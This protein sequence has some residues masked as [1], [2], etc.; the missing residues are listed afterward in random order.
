MDNEKPLELHNKYAYNK[1]DVPVYIDN[2]D[3][4]RKGYYCMGCRKEMQAVKS[5]TED[6]A[7]YFRHDA[8]AIKHEEKCAFSDEAYRHKLAI[9][10]L[11]ISKRIRVPAV[12]KY[13]LDDS[14]PAILLQKARIIEAYTAKAGVSFY[15]NDLGQVLWTQSKDI[16]EEDI[17]FS[18]SVTCFDKQG[19]PILFVEIASN[20]KLSTDKLLQLLQ[21]G[22][23]T[24]SV[25]I[26]RSSPEEI[27]EVFTHTRNTKWLYNYEEAT[28]EYI[29]I[30]TGHT[31]G[32]PDLDEQQRK[33]FRESIRCRKAHLNNVIRRIR[34]SVGSELYRRTESGIRTEIS[35]V[36]RDTDEFRN[37][38]EEKTRRYREELS[39]GNGDVESDFIVEEEQIE[40]NR[41]S[42]EGRYLKKRK[43]IEKTE[44]RILALNRELESKVSSISRDS[45]DTGHYTDERIRSIERKSGDIERRINSI[46]ESG[47]YS[48]G[49]LE[50]EIGRIRAAIERTKLDIDRVNRET[51]SIPAEFNEREQAIADDYRRKEQDIEEAIE[52]ERTAGE[53]IPEQFGIA[54]EKLR[55]RFEQLHQSTYD[56]IERRDF[57]HSPYLSKGYQELLSGERLLHDY[58]KNQRTGTRITAIRKFIASNDFKNWS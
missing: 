16:D 1:E 22:I 4:G 7:S 2:A 50:S 37:D 55:E 11:L 40:N 27:A 30:S 49:R 54:G 39:G 45:G 38:I 57:D 12:Y 23:N 29:P 3:S 32:V 21:I 43:E 17:L 33:L 34:K 25:R 47:K 18:P 31:E 53:T 46:M 5:K 48:R 58:L 56:A 42:L 44:G 8:I 41:R 10:S 35:R 52:R 51:E 20:H 9:E 28:T 15:E 26:P 6:R 36:E 24:V 14:S 13:P 19:T